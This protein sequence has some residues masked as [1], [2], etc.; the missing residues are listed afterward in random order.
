MWHGE[1]GVGHRRGKG[2]GRRG[3]MGGRGRRWVGNCES[4]GMVEGRRGRGRA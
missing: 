1:I 4:S 3:Y 2:C